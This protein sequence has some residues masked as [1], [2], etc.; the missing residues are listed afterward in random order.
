LWIGTQAG[1]SRYDGYRIT[2][3][4]NNPV[5]SRSLADNFIQALYEDGRGRLWIGTKGGLDRFDRDTQSFIHQHIA[6]GS[7]SVTNIIGDGKD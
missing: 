5:D 4:K 2:S 7:L 6:P 3:F 1:L